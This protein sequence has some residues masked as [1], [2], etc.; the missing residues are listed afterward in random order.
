MLITS[1]WQNIQI[2]YKDVLW[3]ISLLSMLDLPSSHIIMLDITFAILLGIVLEAF[4]AH[5]MYICLHNT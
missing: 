5:T 2:M 4:Y 3:N 1:P